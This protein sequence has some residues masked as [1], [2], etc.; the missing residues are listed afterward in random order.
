M[1]QESKAKPTIEQV[2]ELD[3]FLRHLRPDWMNHTRCEVRRKLLAVGLADRSSL[4]YADAVMVNQQLVQIGEKKLGTKT[5]AAIQKYRPFF[6]SVDYAAAKESTGKRLPMGCQKLPEVVLAQLER[7]RPKSSHSHSGSNSTSRSGTPLPPIQSSSSNAQIS[8]VLPSIDEQ[9]PVQE[10]E[11]HGPHGSKH[12]ASIQSEQT[13]TQHKLRHHARKNRKQAKSGNQTTA[14]HEPML[15]GTETA[16]S[17]DTLVSTPAAASVECEGPGSPRFK[18]V[19]SEPSSK[20]KARLFQSIFHKRRVLH[21]W[22][23]A[24][25]SVQYVGVDECIR[26]GLKTN[27][28]DEHQ[29]SDERSQNELLRNSILA[30][31]AASRGCLASKDLVELKKLPPL[32]AL[33]RS[34]MIMYGSL[35]NARHVFRTIVWHRH[36]GQLEMSFE[37]F[38]W[39]LIRIGIAAT[40]ITVLHDMQEL[41]DI[42]DGDQNGSISL[43]ELFG[44]AESLTRDYR[45]TSE[46]WLLYAKAAASAVQSMNPRT[47]H[48]LRSPQSSDMAEQA[49]KIQL[50][51]EEILRVREHLKY[52][53]VMHD[54]FRKAAAACVKDDILSKQVTTSMRRMNQQEINNKAQDIRHRINDMA[55]V[56]SEVA[57]LKA[58]LGFLAEK[59][60]IIREPVREHERASIQHRGSLKFQTVSKKRRPQHHRSQS[61]HLNQMDQVS[62]VK[63]VGVRWRNQ[64][65]PTPADKLE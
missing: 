33:R 62:K 14:K 45:S 37:D 2:A 6:E 17:S 21:K 20:Q 32:V 52:D 25:F 64:T 53:K 40:E 27:G 3:S 23:S 19:E 55:R 35:H 57:G 63:S 47:P 65:T 1:T 4:L 60:I 18:R 43:P 54:D 29:A 48:W 5:W 49:E 31:P 50:E 8:S 51:Q 44:T 15:E 22:W 34:L 38:S 9:M 7:N 26:M 24:A 30:L 41:F 28:V 11:R 58:Q 56:R 36:P 13:P 12:R 16:I 59:E 42:L 39:M 61:H 10:L 46:N